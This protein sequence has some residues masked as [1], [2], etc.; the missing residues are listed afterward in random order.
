YPGAV[1]PRLVLARYHVQQQQHDQ[2]LT[3]LNELPE[4]PRVMLAMGRIEQA[5]GN[6]AEAERLARG[7]LA[8]TPDDD[9]ARKLLTA[10]LLGQGKL[11]EAVEWLESWLESVPDDIPT[12]HRVAAYHL[13]Q[14]RED[15]AQ[16]LYERL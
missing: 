9:D 2:A 13:Q 12:L 14:G 11:E 3:L 6:S 8:A 15:K 4:H 7:A 5:R 1:E 10:A 16:V